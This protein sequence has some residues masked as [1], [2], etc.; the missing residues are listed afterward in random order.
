MT[1][2]RWIIVAVVLALAAAFLLRGG[3]DGTS[4]RV[5]EVQVAETFTSTVT[6]SGEV[7][8]TRYA[9]IGSDLMG[10]VVQLLVEE[11][12]DVESGQVLARLDAVQAEAAA[13]AATA[14]VSTLE[15]ER[16]SSREAVRSATSERNAAEAQAVE[17]RANLRRAIELQDQGIFSQ[18]QRD[19]AQAQAD[20]AEARLNAAVAQLQRAQQQAMA[21]ERR[22]AQARAQASGSE[23]LLAK[24]EIVAP[25]AGRVT[26]LGVR[27]GEMVVIG[28]QN[29]PGTTLMTISDLSEINA[30]I[31]VAEADVPRVQLGQKARIVLEALPGREFM[32]EVVE[33]GASALPVSGAGAAAREFRVV[34]RFT[35]P[36][37]ALRPGF[38]C[39]AEIITEE[40]PDAR[41]VPLQAVV[42]RPGADGSEQTGVFV[43]QDGAAAFTPVT[44]GIIGG[45]RMQVDGVDTGTPVIVGPYQALRTLQDGDAV[46]AA[47]D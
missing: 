45:I 47:Q 21:A 13:A 40:Q 31:K 42:I 38:S 43:L 24:T 6:A 9:D 2:R 41:T 3:P 26:R 14:A 39:D 27:E 10:R 25:I 28:I 4:V 11:G 23:D 35:V 46:V 30:E 44:T 15:A 19:T 22:I 18:A 33:I 17:A 7:V 37:T 32:A 29:Q 20:A 1:R 8:A 12:E 36:D 16:E 34:L 5:E